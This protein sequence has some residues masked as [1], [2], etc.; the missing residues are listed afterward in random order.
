MQSVTQRLKDRYMVLS[1]LILRISEIQ[2]QAPA[3]MLDLLNHKIEQT[4]ATIAGVKGTL[5][6]TQRDWNIL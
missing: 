4:Q 2:T 3:R 5:E 6:D 1:S